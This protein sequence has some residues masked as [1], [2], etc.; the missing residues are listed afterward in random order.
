LV[1]DSLARIDGVLGFRLKAIVGGGTWIVTEYEGKKGYNARTSGTN[2]DF[3]TKGGQFIRQINV[4]HEF[5]HV[6]DNSPGKANIFSNALATRHKF[7]PNFINDAGF[8]EKASL[9]TQFVF[10]PNYGTAEALQHPDTDTVEHW[11][12]VFAN[13]VAGN[14]RGNMADMVRLEEFQK[15]P[16]QLMYDFAYWAITVHAR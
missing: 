13:Y 8:L 3:R 1:Y 7:E 11:A 2:V 10:D 4:Y 14:I 12:D 6:L 15:S 16:G 5:G 9:K